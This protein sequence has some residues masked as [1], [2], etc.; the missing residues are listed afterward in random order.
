M[1]TFIAIIISLW[2][3]G[4][5][6]LMAK[7]MRDDGPGT[8]IS[9]YPMAILLAP[10]L[11]IGLSITISFGLFHY[12]HLSW[13]DGFNFKDGK[14]LFSIYM[15]MSNKE[16]FFTGLVMLPVYSAFWGMVFWIAAGISGTAMYGLWV[17][18][19][20]AIKVLIKPFGLLLKRFNIDIPKMFSHTVILVEAL[21]ERYSEWRL[22]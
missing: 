15:N 8:D 9:D 16:R 7:H 2:G 3:I 11:A 4:I 18:I 1:E 22:K 5:Y 19:T 12:D 17:G 6:T 10:M 13:F 21:I 20:T 14:T